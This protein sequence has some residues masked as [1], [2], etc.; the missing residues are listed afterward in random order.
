M[1]GNA[2]RNIKLRYDTAMPASL[3]CTRRKQNGIVCGSPLDHENYP[4]WCSQCRADYNREY[5]GLRDQMQN[6]KGFAA[7]VTAMRE[8]LV[9]EFMAQGSVG[10]S[11]YE[12][13]ILINQAPGPVRDSSD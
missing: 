9:S 8:V 7:G 1:E 12:V 3:Q 6:G 10:F 5:R 2:Q 4:R 13:A 11:G